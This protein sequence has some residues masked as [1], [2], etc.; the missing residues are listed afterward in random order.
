MVFELI[1]GAFIA[2]YSLAVVLVVA[3]PKGRVFGNLRTA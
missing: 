3:L 1:T 2:A